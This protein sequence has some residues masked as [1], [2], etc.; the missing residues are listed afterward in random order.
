MGDFGGGYTDADGL[1]SVEAWDC[2]PGC[3][4]A[5]MDAQSGPAGSVVKHVQH[6]NHSAKSVGT[7]GWNGPKNAPSSFGDSGGASRFFPVTAWSAVDLEFAFKYHAKA[8]AAERPGKADPDDEAHP[9]VKPLGV[10]LWLARLITPPGGTVLDLFAGTA[11]TLEACAM[12]GFQGIG[13]EKDPK[14]CG[15]A[16]ERLA[17]IGGRDRAI[18]ARR[19]KPVP[20]DDL[21][22]F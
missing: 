21:T 18:R 7:V 13:I 2:V 19:R 20:D 3:P 17:D 5:E 10:M 22:L 4:V 8:S 11:P 16:C 1:E 12:L 6:S 9:T 14:S 15:L